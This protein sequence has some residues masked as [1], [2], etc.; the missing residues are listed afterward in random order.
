[1][2]YTDHQALQFTSSQTINN[3]MHSRWVAYIQ[4]FSFSLKHKSGV[5]NKVVD[6]LSQRASLLVTLWTKVIGFD[7]LKELYEED[8]DFGRVWI[9][10]QQT[11]FVM[12][13][14]HL[15]DGFLFQ[16]NQLYIPWSSLR[17]Q[18]VRKLHG[19][20]LGGHTRWDKT[21]AFV[22]ERYYWPQLKWDVVNLM[23]KCPIC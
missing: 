21:I 4:C 11:Q 3:R 16:G 10:C 7:Y 18:V 6:A 14:I 1:M 13:G 22:D 12:D 8:E 5:T 17:E 20:G 9:Q 23:R 15:Q 19:R 2:L